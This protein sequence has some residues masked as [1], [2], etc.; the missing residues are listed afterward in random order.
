MTLIA[1]FP[2]GSNGFWALSGK[3]SGVSGLIL[4]GFPGGSGGVRGF[5]GVSG[6]IKALVQVT[7]L[8]ES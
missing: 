4:G 2:E 1:N 7:A 8:G 6:L 5:P 3:V